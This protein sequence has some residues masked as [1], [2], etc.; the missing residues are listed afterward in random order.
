MAK[1]GQGMGSIF[2]HSSNWFAYQTGINW[3]GIARAMYP[4]THLGTTPYTGT[5]VIMRKT[6]SDLVDIGSIKLKL[7]W[8]RDTTPPIFGD[9]EVVTITSAI[10]KG[11]ASG[12][13][14]TGEA[15]VTSLGVAI[16]MEGMMTCDAECTFTGESW[17]YTAPV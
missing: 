9:A 3:D 5:V 17:S 14:V 10:P 16:E 11:K 1:P 2:G 4:S 7:F 6:P 13:I 12:A 8:D 15:V